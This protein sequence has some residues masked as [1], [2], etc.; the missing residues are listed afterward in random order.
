[1]G[2]VFD[3][4][5]LRRVIDHLRLTQR[6]G[7]STDQYIKITTRFPESWNEHVNED[8]GIPARKLALLN[9]L[10]EVSSCVRLVDFLDLL[11]ASSVSRR[12]E[13]SDEV[14]EDL[15]A[16]LYLV[17]AGHFR[18]ATALLRFA[19]ENSLLDI[20]LRLR[21]RYEAWSKGNLFVPTGTHLIKQV[22]P[23]HFA[24]HDE[25]KSHF[26]ELSRFVHVASADVI[27]PNLE[28][29]FQSERFDLWYR[30]FQSSCFLIT[31]VLLS[32]HRLRTDGPFAGKW[33]LFRLGTGRKKED[34]ERE[35][36]D[37]RLP[38]A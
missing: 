21:T 19:C 38:G 17:L 22:V 12:T 35:I 18:Q 16:S 14:G 31:K 28:I 10:N 3:A 34:L 4:D 1:M 5:K 20:Y 2:H 24:L 7:F 13:L 9:R 8:S 37:Q 30:Y 15:E 11:T 33:R 23:S 29:S 36:G 26:R 32:F 25:L 27:N 6:E